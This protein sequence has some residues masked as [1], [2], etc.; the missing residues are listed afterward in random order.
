MDREIGGEGAS[1]GIGTCEFQ[2]ALVGLGNPARNGQTQPCA[3][4]VA[5]GTRARLI[6]AKKPLENAW[7][8]LGGYSDPRI[9]DAHCVFL[10]AAL[11]SHRDSPKVGRVFDGVIQKI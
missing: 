11:A 7:P 10:I 5:L 9:C 3:T 8:K 4:A 1:R 2:P 6:G